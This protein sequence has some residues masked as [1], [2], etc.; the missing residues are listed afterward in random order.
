EDAPLGPGSARIARAGRRGPHGPDHHHGRRA[1]R[2]EPRARDARLRRARAHRG[3]RWAGGARALERRDARARHPRP[4][5][6][7]RA[8]G[9]RGPLAPPRRAPAGADHRPHRLGER[10]RGGGAGQGRGRLPDEAVLA[11][12]AHRVHRALARR[13]LRARHARP[14]RLREMS[15]EPSS[16]KTDHS[17]AMLYAN[18]LARLYKRVR[19]DE[20]RL[21]RLEARLRELARIS[22]DLVAASSA[23]AAADKLAFELAGALRSE[24]VAIYVARS[25]KLRLLAA[26]G[27]APAKSAFLREEVAAALATP[28]ARSWPE[29]GL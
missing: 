14:E 9:P 23:E 10:V 12:P 16:T 3:A 28:G 11:A 29:L 13:D 18:D 6:P 15:S 25:G 8:L 26:H 21:A 5:A 27:E 19:E 2:P 17:Q 7:G 1:D 4:R 22:L 20:A 24:R